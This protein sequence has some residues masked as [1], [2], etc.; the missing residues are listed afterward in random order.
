MVTCNGAVII[1]LILVSIQFV[2]SVL[3]KILQMKMLAD[4]IFNEIF[5]KLHSFGECFGKFYQNLWESKSSCETGCL[6]G[7]TVL[8]PKQQL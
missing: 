4:S 7:R 2:H 5:L 1:W 8:S 3:L 6:F